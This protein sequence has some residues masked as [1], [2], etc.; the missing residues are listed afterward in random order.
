MQVAAGYDTECA[1]R[2]EHGDER[3]IGR[4]LAERFE[5]VLLITC[6]SR[7]GEEHQSHQMQ[8]E[9]PRLCELAG[10]VDFEV[11]SSAKLTEFQSMRLWS[12]HRLCA[13]GGGGAWG[14]A[15]SGTWRAGGR[16]A[17]A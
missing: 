12:M 3:E 7:K 6:C 4:A 1:R 11:E 14:G 15:G 13:Q 16:G 2:S 10:E 8:K 9:A 17:G 5:R